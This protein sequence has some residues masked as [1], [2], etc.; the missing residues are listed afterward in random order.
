MEAPLPRSL[1]RDLEA[2]ARA[3][4]LVFQAASDAYSFKAL[5]PQQ[6]LRTKLG[7]GGN[8]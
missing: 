2:R 3:S 4:Y 7:Y 1:R 8:F 6:Q 5:V